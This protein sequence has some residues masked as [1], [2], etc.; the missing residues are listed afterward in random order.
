MTICIICN[1]K[2]VPFGTSRKNGNKTPDWESRKMHK[3]CWK[4]RNDLMLLEGR[5]SRVQS[6]KVF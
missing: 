1:K 3:K 4:Q 2:V 5:L 6:P